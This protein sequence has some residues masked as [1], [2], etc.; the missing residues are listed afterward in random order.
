MSV[1]NLHQH[2]TVQKC[3]LQVSGTEIT[4][5]ITHNHTPPKSPAPHDDPFAP[6]D[7]WGLLETPDSCTI[8]LARA[9]EDQEHTITLTGDELVKLRILLDR[10]HD[11]HTRRHWPMPLQPNR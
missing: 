3:S 4:V 5:A 8:T 1:S 2:R 6:A 9:D 11:F 10:L 7:P